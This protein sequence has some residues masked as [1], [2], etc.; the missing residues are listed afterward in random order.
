M[1]GFISLGICA[2]STSPPQRAIVRKKVCDGYV[3]KPI[4]LG[5]W[6]RPAFFSPVWHEREAFSPHRMCI[7]SLSP[8]S[9]PDLSLFLLLMST[10]VPPYLLI[11]SFPWSW[12]GRCRRN[13]S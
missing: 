2:L 1:S 13:V 3:M 11:W 6:S 12:M 7:I 9:N 8:L 5:L 4:F 10:L